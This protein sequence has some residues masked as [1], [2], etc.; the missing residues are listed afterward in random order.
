MWNFEIFFQFCYHVLVVVVRI[1]KTVTIIFFW[2][3]FLIF[4]ASLKCVNLSFFIQDFFLVLRL[5]CSLS[6]MVHCNTLLY[7]LGFFWLLFCLICLDCRW[8]FVRFIKLWSISLAKCHIHSGT[9][10]RDLNSFW[11]RVFVCVCVWHVSNTKAVFQKKN[12]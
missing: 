7:P 4:Q 10:G 9:S 2:I 1:L 3:F 6:G 8:Y 11:T 12:D 5:I